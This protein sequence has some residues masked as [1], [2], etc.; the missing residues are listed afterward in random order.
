MIRGTVSNTDIRHQ[1]AFIWQLWQC[2]AMS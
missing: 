2:H 1:Q